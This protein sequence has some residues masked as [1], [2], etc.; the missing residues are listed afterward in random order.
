MSVRSTRIAL[1]F[2]AGVL[3]A[4]GIGLGYW[5]GLS[6]QAPEDAQT[7]T[8][9]RKVLYWHDPMLPN[10]RYDKP[11]KSSM[12]MTLVPK[13][14]DE[15]GEGG[16]AIAPGT[17]QSLGIR[18]VEVKRGRLAGGIR[19]PGTITWDLR[20]ERVVS[21]RVDAIVERLFVK[22]PYEPVRAGQP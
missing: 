21:A 5:W 2:G 10:E 15:V 17:Q 12:G 18:T 20:Q 22:A 11:G 6:R 9:D 19:V 4:T 8:T 16:I 14:A 1:A 13:Y 3:V 7:A